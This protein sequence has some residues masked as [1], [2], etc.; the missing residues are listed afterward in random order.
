[1][2]GIEVTRIYLSIGER[3]RRHGGTKAFILGMMKDDTVE[4][5]ISVIDFSIESILE[6]F[7]HK[8]DNLTSVWRCA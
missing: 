5:E 6:N 4:G 7:M 1:M 2:I 3:I 8:R